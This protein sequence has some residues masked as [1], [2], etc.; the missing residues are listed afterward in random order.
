VTYV[1]L[2]LGSLSEAQFHG[3]NKL[4]SNLSKKSI[5]KKEKEKK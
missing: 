3:N 5:E 4:Y 1:A 2:D